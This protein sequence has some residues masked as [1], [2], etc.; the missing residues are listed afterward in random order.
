MTTL[1]EF[2]VIPVFRDL[3]G[4]VVVRREVPF[5]S[6]EEARRAACIFAR[7]LGGAVAFRHVNDPSAGTVGQGVIIGKYGV[8]AEARSAHPPVRT[9]PDNVI[10]LMDH[11]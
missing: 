5:S 11:R 1:N 6:E 9:E 2:G 7:V 3:D 8:M 10:R 4:K